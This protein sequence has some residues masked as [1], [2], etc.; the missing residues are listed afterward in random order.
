MPVIT[1]VANEDVPLRPG[2][3]GD[4]LDEDSAAGKGDIEGPSPIQSP[5]ADGAGDDEDDSS[6]ADMP[7]LESFEADKASKPKKEK[8]IVIEDE[9]PEKEVDEDGWLDVLGS[10]ELKKRVIKPGQG[11]DSRPQRSNWVVLNLKGTLDDGTVFEEQKDWRIIL[12]D[13]ETVCGLDITLALMEKGE[14]AEIVIPA[15]LGYG[16]KGREPDVPPKATLHYHVE[17]LDT[18]PAK[19]E[20]ELPFQERLSIGDAKR[21]RGNFWYGRGDYSNAAHCYRRAL[22]FLDD[23]GLNLSESPADLQLLLDTRLKVYNNLT[24]TQMKMEAYEA[25]LKSVDFVLKVQPNNVKALYRKGKIL[26]SQ[27]NVSEAV[28]V[29]KKALKLEPDTKIIQQ[30]LSRLMV[31]KEKEDRAEKAMYKRMF[32]GGSNSSTD[33]NTTGKGSRFGK[34]RNWALA[35]GGVAAAVAAIGVAAYR[36]LGTV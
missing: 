1:E 14:V 33:G 31:R 21:E 23:M 9:E 13:M 3:K 20:S 11:K 12:G 24:A 19:E 8:K 26:A 5:K 35:A 6:F 22:D 17:L 34:I 2:P 30:E 25:A 10:G 29:L 32:G 4:C 16:D 28:S 15:R 7:P 18:Y 36:H 27:G